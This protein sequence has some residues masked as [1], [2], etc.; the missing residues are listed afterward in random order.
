MKYI[1]SLF[2]IIILISCKNTTSNNENVSK[3][4]K[5]L[6]IK[7]ITFL[8]PFKYKLKQNY[9]QSIGYIIPYLYK[10]ENNS[11]SSIYGLNIETLFEI[12]KI[13]NIENFQIFPLRKNCYIV[14]EINDF[15]PLLPKK[16]IDCIGYLKFIETGDDYISVGDNGDLLKYLNSDVPIQ[17]EF[18]INSIIKMNHPNGNSYINELVF[19]NTQDVIRKIL[20]Y[21][22]KGYKNFGYNDI[23][24]GSFSQNDNVI[25][26]YINSLITPE[27]VL[28][29]EKY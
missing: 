28:V 23:L 16:T 15:N 14:G 29:T 12:K 13:N 1:L 3:E 2:F 22:E 4:I 26:E 7:S 27:N 18:S 24:K 9:R 17:T 19:F 6:K 20:S 11:D 5:V 10:V 8:K 21:Q 25:Y